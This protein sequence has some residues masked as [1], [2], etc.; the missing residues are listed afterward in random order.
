[1]SSLLPANVPT[2]RMAHHRDWTM[3]A[4]GCPDHQRLGD[5][6]AHRGGRP[7]WRQAAGGLNK[8]GPS[9]RQILDQAPRHC[10]MPTTDPGETAM[11]PA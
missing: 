3:P 11:D 1:M 8:L 5:M 2:D 4:A 10:R 9:Q 6:A 7:G